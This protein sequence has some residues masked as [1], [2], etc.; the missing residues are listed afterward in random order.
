[1]EA[2][3]ACLRAAVM[4]DVDVGAVFSGARVFELIQSQSF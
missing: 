2:L 4:V 3:T 1:M